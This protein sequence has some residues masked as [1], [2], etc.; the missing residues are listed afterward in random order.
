MAYNND[1]RNKDHKN[2]KSSNDDGNG[3]SNYEYDYDYEYSEGDYDDTSDF[4]TK[5]NELK[6]NQKINSS[7]SKNKKQKDGKTATDASENKKG[8]KNSGSS[9]GNEDYN[10]H[11][12]RNKSSKKATVNIQQP[13]EGKGSKQKGGKGKKK[14][15]QEE[16]EFVKKEKLLKTAPLTKPN[17]EGKQKQESSTNGAKHQQKKHKGAEEYE[18][19]VSQQQTTTII[20]VKKDAIV[21]IKTRAKSK[22]PIVVQEEK[23]HKQ[24]QNAKEDIKIKQASQQTQNNQNKKKNKRNDDDGNDEVYE[25]VNSHTKSK[26]QNQVIITSNKQG[27]LKLTDYQNQEKPPKINNV[28][29]NAN[30]THNKH[31]K[32]AQANHSQKNINLKVGDQSKSNRSS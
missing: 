32:H 12:A 7:G 19:K 24:A 13:D 10:E 14:N 30:D 23:V 29:A 8:K 27:D 28:N 6:S 17:A 11:Y 9:Q 22:R 25:K 1:P 21:E 18:L 26:N 4:Y 16:E 5:K 2:Q 20:E 31:Q 15:Q 3:S